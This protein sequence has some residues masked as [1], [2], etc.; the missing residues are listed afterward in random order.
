MSKQVNSHTK[1]RGRLLGRAVKFARSTLAAQ[2]FT[3]WDPG[4]G[5]GTTYQAML[6]WRPTCQN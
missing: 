1:F 4:R 2:G 3:F 6:R 5:H